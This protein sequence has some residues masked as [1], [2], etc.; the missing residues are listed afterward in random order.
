MQSGKKPATPATNNLFL[1]TDET[2]Q[3]SIKW[4]DN[5][6]SIVQKLLYICKRSRPDI[7][8]AL[9]YLCTRV[10]KPTIED[11]RKLSRVLDFLSN[12]LEDVRIIGADNLDN[13]YMW[14]DASYATHPN[15][16]SHT[17]GAM[18]FGTGILHGKSSKQ[19]SNTKSS[20]EAE[21]VALSDYIPYHIWMII[22][23]RHQEYKIK[24]KIL[25]QDNQSAIKMEV[26]GRNSCTGNSRHIDIRYFLIHD[27][28]KKVN[29]DVVYRFFTKPLQGK[30]FKKFRSA[31]MGHENQ[32]LVWNN[33]HSEKIKNCAKK[34]E[35]VEIRIL[36]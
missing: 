8:P 14:V 9:S 17:G 32:E 29:L 26:N 28:I 2:E 23:L 10:S 24:N 15:M 22:F 16:R 25:Y 35:R 4:S 12:T 31:I 30:T 1:K 6:H 27:R 20:T 34:K 33:K 36:K 19:K 18:S 13:L 21:L 5:F 7:E 11:E 3:L